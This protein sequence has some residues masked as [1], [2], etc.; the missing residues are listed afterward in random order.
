MEDELLVGSN[1]ILP[2]HF[3]Q[4][5]EFD[6]LQVGHVL[7]FHKF[8]NKI[9]IEYEN[10]NIVNVMVCELMLFQKFVR[11]T[12]GRKRKI[13]SGQI[14][15]RAFFSVPGV[16]VHSLISMLKDSNFELTAS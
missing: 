6:L 14:F 7:F 12:K 3:S 11:R 13:D 10:I 4:S 16:N 1:H 5:R 9:E 2:D 8:P 15:E